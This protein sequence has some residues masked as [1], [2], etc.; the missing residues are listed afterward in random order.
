MGE[1]TEIK[2]NPEKTSVLIN[3]KLAHFPKNINTFIRKKVII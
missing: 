1:L 3:K 2:E